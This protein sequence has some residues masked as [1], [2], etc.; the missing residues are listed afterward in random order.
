MMSAYGISSGC[1][2]ALPTAIFLVWARQGELQY[3]TTA[4]T[5][6]WDEPTQDISPSWIMK[7]QASRTTEHQRGMP[8]KNG[9]KPPGGNQGS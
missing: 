6:Q 2:Y 7:T 4:A 5:H 8:E 9:F 3:A 1:G